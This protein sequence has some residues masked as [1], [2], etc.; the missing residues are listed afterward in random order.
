MNKENIICWDCKARPFKCYEL[1]YKEQI[2][3][4]DFIKGE[5]SKCPITATEDQC[6]VCGEKAC[7]KVGEDYL[8]DYCYWEYCDK[9]PSDYRG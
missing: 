3:L 8:C 9:H 7:T 1:S 5:V 6:I 4:D 2:P